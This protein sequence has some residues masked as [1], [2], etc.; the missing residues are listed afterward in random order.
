[1][2]MMASICLFVKFVVNGYHILYISRFKVDVQILRSTMRV[3]FERP[4][5]CL[6]DD[7]CCHLF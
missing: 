5:A 1:M 2:A 3:I 7:V 6:L 4:A